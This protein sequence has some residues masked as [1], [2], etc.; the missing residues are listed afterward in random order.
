MEAL[1]VTKRASP[2]LCAEE[3]RPSGGDGDRASDYTSQSHR[4]G[5]RARLER[6]QQDAKTA[7]IAP[8]ACGVVMIEVVVCGPANG[9]ATQGL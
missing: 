4:W 3:A 5:I 9:I 6:S 2:F 1:R 8:K 7:L